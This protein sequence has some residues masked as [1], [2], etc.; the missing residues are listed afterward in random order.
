MSP[1]SSVP[2]QS[3][4]GTAETSRA[5]LPIPDVVQRAQPTKTP[6]GAG[7]KVACILHSYC[8]TEFSNIYQ[9]T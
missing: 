9:L 8:H 5:S 7:E 1:Q 4:A 2:K 6:D 3:T